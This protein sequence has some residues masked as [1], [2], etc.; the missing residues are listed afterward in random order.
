MRRKLVLGAAAAALVL[1]LAVGSASAGRGVVVKADNYDFSPRTVEV[2]VG[3]KVTWKGKQGRHTV[4]VT[5]TNIDKVLKE[6][7]TVSVSFKQAGTFRYICRPHKDVGMRGKV[8]V[9]R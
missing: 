3:E 4:T 6:G 5:D 7:D 2:G 8:E 9:S 1:P